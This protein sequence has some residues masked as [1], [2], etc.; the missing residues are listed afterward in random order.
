M[1]K[2]DP[3]FCL[4]ALCFD[5]LSYKQLCAFNDPDF[6]PISLNEFLQDDVSLRAARKNRSLVEFY[7]SCTASLPLFVFGRDPEINQVTYLDADLFFFNNPQLV[8]NEISFAS[9]AIIPHHF[10]DHLRNL[11]AMGIFN[12]GWVSF[13]RD[14]EGLRCLSHWR[15]QC[16][17][18]CFD[19]VEGTRFGD[20]GY[21]N[22]WPEL[23]QNLI[24][25]QQ[26]GAN[27]APWNV[28]DVPLSVENGTVWVDGDPL[29]FFH[30]QSLARVS[31]GI[32]KLNF[33]KYKTRPSWLV[34]KE[35]Y[36]P[37]IQQLEA[38]LSSQNL[39]VND[40]R[41]RSPNDTVSIFSNPFNPS[42][43]SFVRKLTKTFKDWIGG[44]YIF[45]RFH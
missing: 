36:H 27:L 35:I 42:I 15:E 2:Y 20:Q 8:F 22:Q 33:R 13:R 31:P 26:K 32:Y 11:E 9:I 17:E 4:W 45:T 19:R 39:T 7:F 44:D 43:I 37:Y 41:L 40:E 29:V 5:D 21:L 18:W 34:K 10:P 24:I 28:G 25:L 6:R 1:R 16:L 12:V 3:D 14:E 30:F 23:Y 38:I